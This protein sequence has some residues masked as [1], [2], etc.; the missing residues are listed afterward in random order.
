MKREIEF[1]GYTRR[2]KKWLHWGL[3]DDVDIHANARIKVWR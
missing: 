2:L 3:L 1:R